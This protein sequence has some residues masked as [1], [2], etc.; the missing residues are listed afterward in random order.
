M[1]TI[2]TVPYIVE[3]QP[4]HVV[5]RRVEEVSLDSNVME[6]VLAVL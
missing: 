6:E 1:T 5:Q 2:I 4:R 3:S